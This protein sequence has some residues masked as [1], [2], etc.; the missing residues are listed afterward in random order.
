[1]GARQQAQAGRKERGKALSPW[2]QVKEGRSTQA[3]RGVVMR[4]QQRRLN[5]GLEGA[6]QSWGGGAIFVQN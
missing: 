2:A 3:G 5:L 6:R 4:V 1:M